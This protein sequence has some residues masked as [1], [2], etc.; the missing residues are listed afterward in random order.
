MNHKGVII[1]ASTPNSAGFSYRQRCLV[2]FLLVNNLSNLHKALQLQDP[3]NDA[4]QTR[5][6]AR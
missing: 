2:H 1:F 3:L 6:R 4:K 5:N